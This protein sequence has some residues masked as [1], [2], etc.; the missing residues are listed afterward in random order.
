[1]LYLTAHRGFAVFNIAF[2]V[3]RVVADLGET[4]GTA[5]NTEI[6]L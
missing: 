3:N 6:N 5:V 4:A 1:M 2:P